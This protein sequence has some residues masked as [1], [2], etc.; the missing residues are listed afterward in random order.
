M[1]HSCDN[2]A[3]IDQASTLPLALRSAVDIKAKATFNVSKLGK[4]SDCFMYSME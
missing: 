3:F 1:L 4:V 2:V